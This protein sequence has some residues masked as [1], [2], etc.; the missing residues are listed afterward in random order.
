MLNL[1]ECTALETLAIY[2]NVDFCPWKP[3]PL[4]D[5][6]PFWEYVEII[7]EDL[8]ACLR[9]VELALED[10]EEAEW[11]EEVLHE[12]DWRH[13]QRTLNCLPNLEKVQFHTYQLCTYDHYVENY[14]YPLEDW[15]QDLIRKKLPLLEKRNLLDF[16]GPG[17]RRPNIA[18]D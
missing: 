4:L 7:C 15:T 14:K 17:G 11:I 2:I 13:I 18:F 9:R 8:P 5:F 3:R 16:I 12:V 1:G 6:H 10:R